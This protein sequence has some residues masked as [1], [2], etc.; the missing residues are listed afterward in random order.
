MYKRQAKYVDTDFARKN[1]ARFVEEMR[2]GPNTRG[3]IYGTIHRQSTELLMELLEEAGLCAMVG[4][5]NMDRHSPA[6]P[7]PAGT[8]L[9]F[10]PCV[11][12]SESVRVLSRRQVKIGFLVSALPYVLDISV[13]ISGVSLLERLQAGDREQAE[14]AADKLSRLCLSLI[15]ILPSASPARTPRSPLTARFISVFASLTPSREPC[16]PTMPTRSWA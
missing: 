2:K 5:V 14:N 15:H 16:W 6:F 4:K 3:C 10:A 8:V 9:L 1:Y 7:A 12:R 11:R 13:T